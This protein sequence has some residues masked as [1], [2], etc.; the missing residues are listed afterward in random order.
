MYKTVARALRE[1]VL[2]V[3][4]SRVIPCLRTIRQLALATQMCNPAADRTVTRSVV[5]KLTPFTTWLL[6]F[7]SA[8]SPALGVRF[9]GVAA[10]PRP[11]HQR[12]G[13]CR[14]RC[15]RAWR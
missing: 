15:R 14:H 12:S 7:Q 9:V 11:C 6:T 13:P 4:V 10:H 1:A 2:E 5:A 3:S 8:K